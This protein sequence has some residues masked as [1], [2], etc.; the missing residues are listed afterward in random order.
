M[1][2]IFQYLFFILIVVF[3]ATLTSCDIREE[4]TFENDGTG[5]IL[6]TYDL[7][8]VMGIMPTSDA[9][10]KE[11]VDTI[12]DFDQLMSSEEFKKE[13]EDSI[14]NLSAEQKEAFD[15]LKGMTMQL[16]MN[17]ETWITGF[18]WSFE[19]INNLKDAFTKINNAQ[20]FQN[21]NEE[22]GMKETPLY[23]NMSGENQDVKY[24]FDGNSFTRL[25]SVKEEISEEDKNKIKKTLKM[26]GDSEKLLSNLKYTIILNFPKPIKT[27]DNKNAK[28]S[29][30]RKTVEINYP[31]DT[32]IYKPKLLSLNIKLK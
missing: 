16:K 18:G 24:S 6:Y 21:G 2:N 32:Y 8:A 15:A 9:N 29:N 7:S 10:T 26:S 12:L 3:T 20:N 30:N 5:S 23:K 13:Y 1:K 19:N 17:S 31:I 22:E 11:D 28:F 14:K 27:I 25:V 4:I